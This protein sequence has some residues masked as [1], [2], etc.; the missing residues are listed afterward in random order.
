MLSVKK[1]WISTKTKGL[2]FT[3]EAPTPG[4]LKLMQWWL[5]LSKVEQDK[6]VAYV[7][8]LAKERGI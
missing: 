7:N 1:T 6:A 3:Q 8:G 4:R 2:L 5:S